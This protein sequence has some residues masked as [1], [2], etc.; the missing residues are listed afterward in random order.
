MIAI[1]AMH[2]TAKLK[3]EVKLKATEAIVNNAYVDDICD[4]AGN[5]NDA[6]TL[7]S[8]VDEVLGAGGLKVK[9]WISNA[10]LDSKERPEEV[11]L[12]GE[13]HTEKVLGTVWLPKEGKFS[14]KIK[15][16]LASESDSA[17]FVPIRLT[18]RQ[19]L[20]KL[21][22]IF[23][24]T[25]AGAAVLIKLKIAM[26][27]LWQL[28]LGWDNQVSPEV[29]RKWIVLFEEIIALNNV[30]FERYLTL[31]NATGDPSLVVFCDTSRLAF[32]ACA[33]MK[34]KLDNGQFGTRF[35]AAKARVAP[36]K[37]LTIPRLELQAAVLA[38]RLGKFI[39]QESR[40]NFER[41]RYLSDSRV[42]LTWIKGETSSFK[43]FVSCR[44]AEIQSNSS[45]EDW[46][47]CPTELNVP[48]DLTK[49][50]AT[51]EVNGRWFNGP[52][53]LQLPED[54]WPLEHSVPDMT[55]V[56]R[57]RRKVQITYATA[58]CQPVMNCREFSTWRRLLRVTAHVLQF[59]RNLG[60]KSSQQ[61][62]N[63]P[64][65]VGSISAE[66]VKDTEEYWKKK[67]QTGLTDRLEKG[68][69]K[70]LSPFIDDKG[71]ISVAVK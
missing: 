68:D 53:F 50:I 69:F 61:S 63:N 11:V 40:F 47:H 41:V 1:T 54:H 48:D 42:A 37:E 38:S 17:V 14:F 57:E 25:G 22:G 9:K 71:I 32:G 39:L 23:D 49:R 59:C 13:S 16:D 27:E 20:S 4:S 2:K 66:E 33:Y 46:S 58:V 56:N 19:I 3:Q 36:L 35:V 30:K 6:K 45:P 7:I 52:K 28:G 12:G 67:V 24:P 62:D 44:V 15:I 29:K 8:D 21:A 43:P 51:T 64:V 18:K 10:A 60:L 26:E 34:W 55:E 5:A 70:T 31:P 65:Q